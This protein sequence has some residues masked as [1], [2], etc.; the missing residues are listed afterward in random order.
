MHRRFTR[1]MFLSDEDDD[2]GI[3]MSDFCLALIIWV[4]M[5]EKSVIA[6]TVAKAAYDFNTTV[7]VVREALKMS[8][9]VSIRGVNKEPYEQIIELDG[10]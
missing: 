8:P 9:W 4:S 10:E 5:N 2:A 1:D 6:T 3:H 7:D